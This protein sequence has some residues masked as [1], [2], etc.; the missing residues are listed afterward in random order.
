MWY[1]V[2]RHAKEAGSREGLR[3]KHCSWYMQDMSIAAWVVMR[4]VTGACQVYLINANDCFNAG[5]QAE[6]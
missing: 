4:Q 6:C 1:V 5:I 2:V 3:K